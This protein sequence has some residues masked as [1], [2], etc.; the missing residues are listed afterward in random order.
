[1]LFDKMC[2]YPAQELSSKQL[3]GLI[4][5]NSFKWQVRIISSPVPDWRQQ[6]VAIA[7]K[8]S[9]NTES[10]PHENKA[11]NC[12]PQRPSLSS[13]WKWW[14]DQTG[15]PYDPI[16]R[17]VRTDSDDSGRENGHELDKTCLYLSCTRM[18][19]DSELKTVVRTNQKTCNMSMIKLANY[20]I[21]ENQ[22]WW[23][24]AI[25]ANLWSQDGKEGWQ[26][27]A[28]TIRRDS[29][30]QMFKI[31]LG[32]KPAIIN[33]P[34]SQRLSPSGQ[35]CG[36]IGSVF[37]KTGC[38]ASLW[39]LMQRTGID[40]KECLGATAAFITEIRFPKLLTRCENT[41]VLLH[42]IIICGETVSECL[43]HAGTVFNIVQI[44]AYLDS[45]YWLWNALL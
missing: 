37:L 42:D 17:S 8:R 29:K 45:K 22:Q 31:L 19:L 5:F 28:W 41:T 34:Q 20:Q 39:S 27:C 14:Q 3:S 13:L 40:M 7:A 12:G 1:M 44:S 25:T 35:V 6:T 15:P 43:L 21:C 30:I 18:I 36:Q 4:K 9:C 2:M 10:V 26:L 32:P 38:S 23:L 16:T 11:Q 24:Q 33:P